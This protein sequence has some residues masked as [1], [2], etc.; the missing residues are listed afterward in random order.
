MS[1]RALENF[2]SLPYTSS[3]LGKARSSRGEPL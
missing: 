1:I 3:N 2:I